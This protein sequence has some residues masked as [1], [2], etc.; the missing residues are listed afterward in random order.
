LTQLAIF[1]ILLS[2]Y[3]NVLRETF[4]MRK[5]LLALTA[6][7]VTFVIAIIAFYAGVAVQYAALTQHAATAVQ[8]M[9]PP[10]APYYY[11]EAPAPLLPVAST[12]YNAYGSMTDV[13]L[14]MPPSPMILSASATCEP[15]EPV[16]FIAPYVITVA[17]AQINFLGVESLE[18]TYSDQVSSAFDSAPLILPATHDFGQGCVYRLKLSNLP[19]HPG[20][21]LFPT[22]EIAPIVSETQTFLAHCSVPVNFTN[23][24]FEHVLSGHL[25][26]KVVFLPR[27]NDMLYAETLDNTQIDRG[28]DPVVEASKRGSILAVIRMG[29]KDLSSRTDVSNVRKPAIPIP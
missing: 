11:N 12:P 6:L 5:T 9:P 13:A 19:G 28:V 1:P 16:A 15:C 8:L 17:Q 20:K 2:Q 22:L 23:E 26:T 10:P 7:F 3:R 4:I 29:N 24:D 27:E 18:I 21:E 25:I 14:P